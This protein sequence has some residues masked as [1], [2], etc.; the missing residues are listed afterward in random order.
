[1]TDGQVYIGNTGE[2]C[3]GF[4]VRDGLGIQRIIKEN[5]C[6]IV[7]T[8]RKS[9]IVLK[10][11]EEIGIEKIYQGIKDKK[12]KLMELI[13]KYGMDVNELAYIADDIN[14]LDAICIAK[15]RACPSDAVLEIKQV[16]NYV[17]EYRGGNGAVRD[18]CD[19]LIRLNACS[20]K[21]DM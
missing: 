5:I 21:D 1:M 16:C 7:L 3:K 8:S 2:L 13:E 14:D 4:Y 12:A 17:S 20:G 11:C 18:V 9:D 10:R 6:P 15:I 19:Y